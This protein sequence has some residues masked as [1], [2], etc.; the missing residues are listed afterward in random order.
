MSADRH[1]VAF[2]VYLLL[3]R[4]EEV[5]LL[6][7]AHT[8]WEDGNYSL[9]AGH[10]DDGESAVTA[11]LREAGEEAGVTLD[12]DDL[13]LVHTMHRRDATN[14]VDL[15]FEASRWS[16]E[17]RIMEP[18]KA[19]DLSW[20]PLSTLPPNLIPTVRQALTCIALGEP[21]SEFGW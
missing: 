15:Y 13:E 8:G 2:A 21:F 7:R 20:Y 10:V 12:A 18:N 11:I 16:G 5:L 1:L 19:D 9:V 14:Y 17:P 3:R 6:R 4:G